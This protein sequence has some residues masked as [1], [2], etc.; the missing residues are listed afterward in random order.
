MN[1]RPQRPKR[2]A[3]TGLRYSPTRG[4]GFY[5]TPAGPGDCEAG[6]ST[7]WVSWL[8]VCSPKAE[9]PSA[10]GVRQ[11]T[12]RNG[13]CP[14][15]QWAQPWRNRLNPSDPPSRRV[16][17]ARHFNKRNHHPPPMSALV[18]G[19]QPCL[20][21]RVSVP[22]RPTCAE[23]P[24]VRPAALQAL[25]PGMPRSD[26]PGLQHRTGIGSCSGAVRP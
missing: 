25:S 23:T 20:P 9:G 18:Q 10:M 16:A 5:T 3:L 2:C 8:P 4:R 17:Q 13:C 14:R 7:V 11:R 6:G 19:R 15:L 22:A 21:T 1:L 12:G 26:G 24:Q